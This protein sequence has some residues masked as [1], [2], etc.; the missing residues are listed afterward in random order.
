MQNP[1]SLL[2]LEL[3]YYYS[4]HLSKTLLPSAIDIAEVTLSSFKPNLKYMAE[5]DQ[6]IGK[7]KKNL[8]KWN[9]DVEERMNDMH[10]L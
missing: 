1:S 4:I 2:Y 3:G 10:A 6:I 9:K 7:L 8:T 5:M